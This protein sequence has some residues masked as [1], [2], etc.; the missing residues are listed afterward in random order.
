MYKFVHYFFGSAPSRWIRRARAEPEN[1]QLPAESRAGPAQL[2]LAGEWGA[3]HLPRGA[4]LALDPAA[5]GTRE[6]Q[7][8]SRWPRCGTRPPRWSA[9]TPA[10]KY[11]RRRN[12][13]SARAMRSPLV[14]DLHVGPRVVGTKAASETCRKEGVLKLNGSIF[15]PE[16]NA[17]RST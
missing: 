7:G 2:P 6:G 16:N 4:T 14:G 1:P 9:P 17:L 12:G 10:G 11:K 8:R 5:E 3:Q 15:G 13:A